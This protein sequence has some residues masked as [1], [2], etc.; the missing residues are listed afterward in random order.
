MSDSTKATRIA[1]ITSRY[2]IMLLQEIRDS[3]GSSYRQLLS[4]M[5]S[6]G[7]YSMSIS[8]RLGRS[9]YKEQYAF[10]YR[11]DKIQILDSYQYDDGVDDGTDVFEREPF[12]VLVHPTNSCTSFGII[13]LHSKPTA[14]VSE[15]SALN[16]V[17]KA[18][19]S[20]WNIQ[21][22]MIMGDLNADCTYARESSLADKKIYG[23]KTYKWLIDWS[24]DTTTGTTQC[25]YDR[26]I[27]RGQE[28]A[29]VLVADS[30]QVYLFDQRM[31]L[32]K[33]QMLDISDHYPVE[34]QLRFPSLCDPCSSTET[35]CS[36]L[37]SPQLYC[38]CK[39]GRPT[40]Q[41]DKIG[42]C[43][44]SWMICILLLRYKCIIFVYYG[45]NT[46]YSSTLHHHLPLSETVINF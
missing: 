29:S 37:T 25:A 26:I 44:D 18:V 19:E 1:E 22:V 27:S 2:D 42:L 23:D 8:E 4:M 43:A 38:R 24:Q 45:D 40:K 12:C 31:N 16:D 13:A 30:A 5:Q 7:N 33:E 41:R 39:H 32:S 46:N 20:K 14:A 3:T 15:I 6:Y 28:L 35:T 17:R 9:S 21:D 11:S 36:S 34:V 10:L